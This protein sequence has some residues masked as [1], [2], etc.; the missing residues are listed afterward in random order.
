MPFA[1]NPLAQSGTY[2]YVEN[3]DD[4]I[5]AIS[6][7]NI[8]TVWNT[9][10]IDPIT[11]SVTADAVSPTQGDVSV[12]SASYLQID[13]V[14]HYELSLSCWYDDTVLFNVIGAKEVSP[15]S[16]LYFRDGTSEESA[17]QGVF[18]RVS[19]N[20]LSSNRD[21]NISGVNRISLKFVAIFD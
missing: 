5:Q 14:R 2:D 15:V 20:T 8:I 11:G 19:S 3:A 4:T 1:K 7:N 6:Y 9:R 16:A 10:Q 12:L 18:R 17:G 21:D 13:N